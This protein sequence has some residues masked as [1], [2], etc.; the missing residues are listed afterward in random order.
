[1]VTKTQDAP[2]QD[3]PQD[4]D[5]D[6]WL[7]NARLPERSVTVFGRADLVAEHQE[8]EEQ[9]TR[10]RAVYS[11]DERLV[12]PTTDLAARMRELSEQMQASALTFRLRA[13]TR[14]EQDAARAG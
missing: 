10:A 8:L 3:A 1:M 5:L 11:D 12:D 14:D 4:F 7:D 6:D 2:V 13:L 9:L